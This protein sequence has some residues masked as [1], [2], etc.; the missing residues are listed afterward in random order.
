V[1]RATQGWQK[2]QHSRVKQTRRVCRGLDEMLYL[3]GRKTS[4][5]RLVE[6]LL[7]RTAA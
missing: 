7:C 1:A 3:C 4:M 5:P 2:W 6:S